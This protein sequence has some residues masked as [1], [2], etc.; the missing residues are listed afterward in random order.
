MEDRGSSARN[1]S[2]SRQDGRIF[3]I[4]TTEMSVR[5]SVT[6]IRPLPSDSTTTSDPV[7]AI[8]KF[9]PD[10]PTEADRNAWRR[11]VRAAAA[12]AAGSS[13]SPAGASGI[14]VRKISLISAR[15]LWMAGTRMWLG[16]SW[17]SCTMSSARSVS[18]ALMP[19]AASASFSPVSWVA[20]DF[21]LTTPSAPALRT[22]PATIALASSASAAQCTCPPARVTLASSRSR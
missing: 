17:P 6:H 5:G 2:R 14:W 11:C 10:T 13:V 8:A 18:S 1:T 4:P 22:R 15:F 7:S 19:S 21:T 12:S 20:I 16:R 3:S 9:A